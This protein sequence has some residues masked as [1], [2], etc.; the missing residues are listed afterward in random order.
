MPVPTPEQ[1]SRVGTR[2]DPRSAPTESY[3]FC[4]VSRSRQCGESDTGVLMPFQ[5]STED[6]PGRHFRKLVERVSGSAEPSPGIPRG[7]GTWLRL[8]GCDAGGAD[9]VC[10]QRRRENRL[11]GLRP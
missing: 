7:P 11:S 2:R 9:Q 4:I 10:A 1:V 5:W 3:E 8:M 6:W